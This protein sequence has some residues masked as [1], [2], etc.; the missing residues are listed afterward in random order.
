MWSLLMMVIGSTKFF[1]P[2]LF[3]QNNYQCPVVISNCKDYVCSLPLY[4]R[5][6]F[7]QDGPFSLASKFGDYR[8]SNN[9]ELDRLQSFIY[10]G[11]VVGVLAGAFINQYITTRMLLIITVIVSIVGLGTTLLS[12]TLLISSIGLFLTSAAT[13]ISMQMLQ[14]YI[15]ETVS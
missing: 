9:V 15:V 13:A 2:Y 4:E 8:C 11:G 6:H 1:L 12:Q 3:Y 10:F 7:I 14:C 5:D